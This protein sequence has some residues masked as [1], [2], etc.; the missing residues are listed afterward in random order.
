MRSTWDFRLGTGGDRVKSMS[1]ATLV[2][3]WPLSACWAFSSQFVTSGTKTTDKQLSWQKNT[4]FLPSWRMNWTALQLCTLT[5]CCKHYRLLKSGCSLSVYW[6]L[7]LSPGQSSVRD[8]LKMQTN[9]TN[10]SRTKH[11]HAGGIWPPTALSGHFWVRFWEPRFHF[12][13][14]DFTSKLKL[15]TYDGIPLLIPG[16]KQPLSYLCASEG[17]HF[18]VLN[19]GGSFADIHGVVKEGLIFDWELLWPLP[20]RREKRSLVFSLRDGFVLGK[21]LQRKE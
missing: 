13:S 8:L 15:L 17:F 20:N 5:R 6:L 18:S 10:S 21:V 19:A 12:M 4:F 14:Y 1:T 16:C 3:K 2:R 11:T 7:L 9:W